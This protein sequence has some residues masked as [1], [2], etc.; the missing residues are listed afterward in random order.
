MLVVAQT[1]LTKSVRLRES[2]SVITWLV[3]VLT[4]LTKS[5]RPRESVS[6]ST[7]RVEGQ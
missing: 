2:V 4:R 5:V 3:A 1:R 7:M 6:M